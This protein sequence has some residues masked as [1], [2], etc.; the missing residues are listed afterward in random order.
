MRN[1][2]AKTLE[3]LPIAI[4][5]LRGFAEEIEELY[6][7]FHTTRQRESF[8]R[9]KPTLDRLACFVALAL[10]I[11]DLVTKIDAPEERN[12]REQLVDEIMAARA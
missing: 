7:A 12:L 5:N 6:N 10:R 4:G 2:D 3:L 11:P 1:I 9:C 8:E